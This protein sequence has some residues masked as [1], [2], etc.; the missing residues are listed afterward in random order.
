MAFQTVTLDTRPPIALLTLARPERGNRI[1]QDMLAELRLAV[2]A[3]AEGGLVWAVVIAGEGEHF[4][5][6]WDS[7]VLAEGAASVAAA[8]R[9]RWGGS[10]FDFI[11]ESPLPI[12]AAIQ[13]DAFSAGLELALA[14]DLRLA[15][16]NA[17]FGFPEVAE[18]RL[19]MGGGTQRLAR[20]AG[21]GTALEMI[22]TA[23][24][25][26]AE[27]ARSRGL[28]SAVVESERLLAAAEQQA[29]VIAE[30]GPL[31]VRLAKEAIAHGLDLPLPQALR[32]ETDLTILL[33]TTRD[34]AEGVQ[35][36]KEKRSPHFIGE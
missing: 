27:A 21:R 33:Q 31:A 29:R 7:S 2:G 4:S 19:P 25:I 12:I 15:A 20:L 10:F 5:L 35:A 23:E 8:Q 32:L 6:G 22:L 30:R 34:R 17:R 16:P 26:D 24:A 1:D 9:A 11:A 28:V 14:C 18:G 3:L 36:F 13:G